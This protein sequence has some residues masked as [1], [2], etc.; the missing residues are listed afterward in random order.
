MARAPGSGW[1]GPRQKELPSKRPGH[2]G[3]A[4]LLLLEN[5]GRL[6]EPPHLCLEVQVLYASLR[7][8]LG[9]LGDHE[10]EGRS[11]LG[12]VIRNGLPL[13]RAV[14]VLECLGGLHL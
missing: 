10:V 2:G 8:L 6:L 9:L 7:L 12:G 3:L 5:L 13:P 4:T 1:P 14:S 11:V